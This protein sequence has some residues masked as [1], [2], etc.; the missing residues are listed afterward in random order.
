MGYSNAGTLEFL[1]DADENYYFIEMNPRIQVEHTVT[2]MVTGVDIV[3]TQ[4]LVAEGYNLFSEKIGIKSQ[5]DV[6]CNGHAIQL[7]VTTEDPTNNFLPDT[8][9]ITVYRSPAGNGIRLDGGNVFTGAEVMPYYDS[10]LVKIIA[11]DRTFDGTVTENAV[12]A[13]KETR[14]RGSKNKHT[15]PYKCCPERRIASRGNAQRPSSRKRPSCSTSAQS[16]DRASKIAEFIGN[17]IVN[18]SK[19]REARFRPHR[20]LPKYE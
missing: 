11:Y 3:T 20:V 2:E 1:V 15:F 17:Q 16:K 4:I 14:I 13:L 19:G 8:G 7:R 18:E 6:H 12:R 9:K 5:E 10:L